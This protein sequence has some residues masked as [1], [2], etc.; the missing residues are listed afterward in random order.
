MNKKH[1]QYTLL[2]LDKNLVYTKTIANR[3]SHAFLLQK[4][5]IIKKLKMSKSKK[6]LIMV[7]RKWFCKNIL[8]R[9]SQNKIID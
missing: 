3:E 5:L 9:K 4:L 6:E 1:K 8:G 2:L 7:G